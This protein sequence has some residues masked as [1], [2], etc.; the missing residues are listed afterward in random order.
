MHYPNCYFQ[1]TTFTYTNMESDSNDFKDS[2]WLHFRGIQC[3]FILYSST[4]QNSLAPCKN[5]PVN[6]WK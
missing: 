5:C 1:N 6:W 3:H 4:S 2:T